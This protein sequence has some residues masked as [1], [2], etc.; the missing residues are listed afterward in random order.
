MK[1]AIVG[2]GAWGKALYSILSENSANVVFVTKQSLKSKLNPTKIDVLVLAVP[3]Q[4]IREVLE[5]IGNIGNM[6]VVNC[7]KGIERGTHKFPFQIVSE[8]GGKKEKYFSL[9]G[10]SFAEELKDKMPT[11]VNLGHNSEK[12]Y[13]NLVKKLFETECLE[14]KVVHGIAALELAGAFKNIY[15]I[16]CGLT[17]GLGF[18]M[19][20]R[21]KVILAALREIHNLMKNLK[22]RIE[23][24][25]IP[26]I[27]GD[28]IL[29]CN[30][31][32]SRNYSFGKLIVNFSVE[33]ALRKITTVE[34]FYTSDSVA[35][36]EKIG[37]MKLPLADMVARCVKIENK[38]I[39]R[40]LVMNTI[41]KNT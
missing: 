9:I 11:V 21:V 24:E 16:A 32:E 34:G 2:N 4:A 17:T 8:K 14:I 3:T 13:I 6:I 39:L 1:V 33:E 20:T 7:A 23:D 27:L 30:S 37:N 31:T 40:Q 15:A 5:K 12:K 25:T 10:P 36:F 22:F 18:G 29:T 26:G 38:G 28:L 41:T 19:N 35:Y